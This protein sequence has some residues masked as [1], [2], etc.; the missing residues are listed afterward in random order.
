MTRPALVSGSVSEIPSSELVEAGRE[1]VEMVSDDGLL[2]GRLKNSQ[3][4]KKLDTLV[5][6]L[7]VNKRSE[8]IKS[9]HSFPSLFSDTP[10]RT[11]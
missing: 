5:A 7:E 4:L 11:H 1:E 3:T 2:Q 8:V 10:S 9:S 6:H